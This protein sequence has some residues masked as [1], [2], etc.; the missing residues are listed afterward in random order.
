M[1]YNNYYPKQVTIVLNCG[2]VLTVVSEN[3]NLTIT[4]GLLKKLKLG[5]TS[6]GKRKKEE[7]EV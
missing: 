7:E 6:I 1:Q 4:V 3:I 5:G 2:L